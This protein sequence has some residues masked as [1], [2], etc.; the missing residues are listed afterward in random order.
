MSRVWSRNPASWTTSADFSSASPGGR[1]SGRP[2][3]ARISAVVFRGQLDG[4]GDPA[5]RARIIRGLRFAASLEETFCC[6]RGA[7][8]AAAP[9]CMNCARQAASD[10]DSDET[11]GL[12]LW[13][14]LRKSR[15]STRRSM[16]SPSARATGALSSAAKT[17]CR[18]IPLTRPWRT[19]RRSRSRSATPA[20]R[21]RRCP[22]CSR[23]MRAARPLP[24]WR[25][26]RRCQ[27]F[28]HLPALRARGS[29]RREQVR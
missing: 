5:R 20:W 22:E 12:R 2:P 3:S 7:A 4:F 1:L 6:K 29:Q 17:S 26:P 14:S 21:A 19:A 8:L 28:R 25:R 16:P 11:G 13:L 23:S 10:C 24:T 15:H 9:G 18:S 27:R